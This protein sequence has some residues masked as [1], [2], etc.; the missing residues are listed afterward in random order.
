M[1]MKLHI[2]LPIFVMRQLVRHRIAS[3]NERSGRY[4][5]FDPEWYVPSEI[6]AQ[7]SYDRQKSVSRKGPTYLSCRIRSCER[8]LRDIHKL[9]RQVARD[10]AHRAANFHVPEI[11]GLKHQSL[12]NF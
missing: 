6:R 5:Q 10:S 1:V 4:T 7:D 12:M 9:S 2:K 3:I 8:F 11:T